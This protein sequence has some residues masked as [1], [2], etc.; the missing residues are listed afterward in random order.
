[1]Q[2]GFHGF[3]KNRPAL[4]R[5]DV[6]VLVIGEGHEWETGEYAVDAVAAGLAAGLVVVGHVPSE[7]EG[8][9]EAARWLAELLPEVPVELVATADPFRVL[10]A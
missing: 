2:P 7:Q 10:P 6:D 3:E 4:A 5:P 9:A 1:V 8:M